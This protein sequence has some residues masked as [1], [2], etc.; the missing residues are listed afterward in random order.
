M[1]T[2]FTIQSNFTHG[3]L[4]ER[5]LARTDFSGYYKGAQRLSNFLTIPQ[6]GAKRRFGTTWLSDISSDVTSDSEL[7]LTVL[8]YKTESDYPLIFKPGKIQIYDDSI[9][10]ANVDTPYLASEISE[11][12]WAQTDS[13]LVVVHPNHAPRL[14]IRGA[15]SDVWTFEAALFKFYPTE[16]FDGGYDAI[17]FTPSDKTGDITLTASADIFTDEVVGGLFIGNSGTLRID[18]YTSATEVSGYTIIDFDSTSAIRGVLSY[19]AYP[20]FSNTKGWPQTIGFYQNRLTFG[21]T[22][23]LPSGVWM[24]V[25]N[26]YFNFDT[27]EGLDD[28]SISA[29]IRSR[30]AAVIK[31][32]LGTNSLL[33]FTTS[34]V[35]SA[36]NNFGEAITPGNFSLTQQ[37]SSAVAE[38][39]PVQMDNQVFYLDK[40]KQIVRSLDYDI[41]RQSY[42]ATNISVVTDVVNNPVDMCTY[43]NPSI[44]DGSFVILVNGDGTLAVYTTLQEQNVQGWSR[45]N[46]TGDFLQ[47]ADTSDNVWFIVKRM[48]EGVEKYYLEQLDFNVYTDATI[49]GTNSPDSNI[50]T[51]LAMLN[52]LDVY[53]SS[54][55]AVFGPYTVANGEITIEFPVGSYTVG[56]NYIP[57]LVPMP[58]NI[59]TGRGSNL[60]LPKMIKQIVVDYIDSYGVYVDGYPI[61]ELNLPITLDSAPELKTGFSRVIVREG[62]KPIIRNGMYNFVQIN[63]TQPLPFPLLIR[64]VNLEVE[65]DLPQEG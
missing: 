56:L 33:I 11:L 29:F 14:L 15:T 52:D 47:C 2:I 25:I 49:S 64:G 54:A 4:S 30:R 58:I 3:E 37:A 61:P 35:F 24:S 53:V 10:V 34:G 36:A 65:M 17:N 46:T 60:Y 32:I 7:Q 44:D 55:G 43:E 26:D 50:I 20:V 38:V 63:I 13:T 8:E 19:L 21:G 57:E 22:P 62:W 42:E 45:H 40:G 12:R 31:D 48:I 28:Q 18:A 51:N 1:A 59:D 41:S 16:D 23:A 5:L 9:L 27:G 39:N 6:G